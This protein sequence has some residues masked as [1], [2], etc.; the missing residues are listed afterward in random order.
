MDDR[1][2][3]PNTNFE[4]HR[5]LNKKSVS[6]TVNFLELLKQQTS[7]RTFDA[8]RQNFWAVGF[9]FTL[10]PAPFLEQCAKNDISLAEAQK[11]PETGKSVSQQFARFYPM[12]NY[13][14]FS[15]F[16]E[17][18]LQAIETTHF[19]FRSAM[20]LMN[21]LPNFPL[22]KMF[23][24]KMNYLANSNNSLRFFE[25][26]EEIHRVLEFA[27]D[28]KPLRQQLL[29]DEKFVN[30]CTYGGT[31]YNLGDL[32][33]QSINPHEL[34]M[35]GNIL[36]AIV[37][38][39]GRNLKEFD[40]TMTEMITSHKSFKDQT[41]NPSFEAKAEAKAVYEGVLRMRYT[42]HIGA[43]IQF[44]DLLRKLRFENG[45]G[46]GD[47]NTAAFYRGN[48]IKRKYY[49]GV[50]NLLALS[51]FKTGNFGISLR[52]LEKLYERTQQRQTTGAD[53][54]A[55]IATF[56][57]LN[58]PLMRASIAYNLFVT[59]FNLGEYTKAISL[60]ESV[61]ST[62]A[63]NHRYWY[64]RGRCHFNLWLKEVETAK[65]RQIT[66]L[67]KAVRAEAKTLERRKVA[68]LTAPEFGLDSTAHAIGLN[69]FRSLETELTS[70]HAV[71]AIS[72]FENSLNILQ[73]LNNK[74]YL[75]FIFQPS[76]QRFKEYFNA[77][78]SAV[79][80]EVPRHLLSVLEHLTYLYL[81]A[82]KP[83]Q[84]LKTITMA[85]TSASLKM[86][87]GQRAKFAAYHL[88]AAHL[89]KRSGV[90]KSSL[91]Q[92]DTAIAGAEKENALAKVSRDSQ[93][94]ALPLSF[95][96][97]YNRLAAQYKD[98]ESAR[99]ALQKLLEESERLSE[100]V[101][102][103]CEPLLRNALFFYFSRV[104]FS[105]DMLRQITSPN[106]DVSKSL[107]NKNGKSSGSF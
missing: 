12:Y 46:I 100:S 37:Y 16:A 30:S 29:G 90:L 97:K 83:M 91:S 32:D 35:T 81:L 5:V 58:D 104:E 42:E 41:S 6:E 106:F 49:V 45:V 60:A 99:A 15:K 19:S 88:K 87:A 24:S 28:F 33:Q 9:F 84:A 80:A 92:V 73:N 76:T 44:L 78:K 67:T 2:D 96:L 56:S 20:R 23:L 54:P 79:A 72:C 64:F 85:T 70:Q 27:R 93:T 26:F 65:V 47:L 95:I 55:S 17:Q 18:N 22:L 71:L 77:T 103:V 61:L 59:L 105:R 39:F 75:G 101:R 1:K 98:K 102:P 68:L 25:H 89:L 31:F 62:F 74:E 82:N 10:N 53:K 3:G 69:S 107:L 4:L 66:E 34:E 36:L 11:L 43:V 52:I 48:Q 50:M 86:T 51:N 94:V 13:L 57:Q 8:G 40:R 63:S 21:A 14:Y 7:D 38:L